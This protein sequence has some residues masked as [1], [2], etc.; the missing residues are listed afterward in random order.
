V[1]ARRARVLNGL[2]RVCPAAPCA[3]RTWGTR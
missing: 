1:A 3:A 2:S